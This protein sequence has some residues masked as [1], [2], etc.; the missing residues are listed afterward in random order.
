[1]Q[2]TDQRIVELLLRNLAEVFGEGD[3]QTVLNRRKGKL[4][5][6]SPLNA[7]A[8]DQLFR[9][10]RTHNGWLPK[11]VSDELLEQLYELVKWGPTSANLGPMR[12]V[13]VKSKEA[14]ER[15]KP[16]WARTRSGSDRSWQRWTRGARRRP[17]ATPLP[18]ARAAMPVSRA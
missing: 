1:M 11:P 6:T 17:E 15:L 7:E 13:F 18:S 2:A 10:A 3:P 12:L 5:M 16:T 4:K 9:T 14:K 8:L